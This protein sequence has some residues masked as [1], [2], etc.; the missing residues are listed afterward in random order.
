MNEIYIDIECYSCYQISNLGNVR[1]VKLGKIKILKQHKLPKGYRQVTLYDDQGIPKRF[2]V[3]RLVAKAFIPNPDNLPI[4][5]HKDENPSNNCVDNLEW[6]TQSH[7]CR[8]DDVHIK[9]GLHHRNNNQSK[10]VF[11]YT[12]DGEFVKEWPS[13]K[14]VERQLGFENTRISACSNGN[15]MQSYGFMWFCDYKGDKIDGYVKPSDPRCVKIIQRTKEGNIVKVWD[16]FRQIERETN[17]SRGNIQKCAHKQGYY[18]TAYGY[19]WEIA[20]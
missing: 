18:K 14:E 20:S 10:K 12:L 11:Q 17:Y 4:V 6:C 16:S 3:H 1:S 8:W 9:R 15:Q 19:I 13:C 2:Y 5:N 7:N